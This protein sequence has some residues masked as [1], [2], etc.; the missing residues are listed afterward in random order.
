M[1]YLPPRCCPA[2]FTGF[3]L[4][5]LPLMLV[6]MAL[7]IAIVSEVGEWESTATWVF[8]GARECS[9]IVY[10]NMGTPGILADAVIT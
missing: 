10:L 9:G 5:G 4:V 6:R 3:D 7:A 1:D 2:V 8:Q